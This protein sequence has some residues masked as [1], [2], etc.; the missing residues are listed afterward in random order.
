MHIGAATGGFLKKGPRTK[1]MM[2][3][4]WPPL[5][6][7]PARRSIPIARLRNTPLPP[8]C[9]NHSFV[10][11]ARGGQKTYQSS[12]SVVRRSR[13]SSGYRGDLAITALWL[14]LAQNDLT[15][16]RMLDVVSTTPSWAKSSRIPCSIGTFFF[17][18]FRSLGSRH[19][20]IIPSWVEAVGSRWPK[21]TLTDLFRKRVQENYQ[22]VRKLTVSKYCPDRTIQVDC[23]TA[24]KYRRWAAWA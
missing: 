16:I 10:M 22:R 21:R 12:V 6:L 15:L 13:P 2:S 1:S 9:P 24:A 20:K 8:L 11:N 4:T 23:S 18:V 17:R 14:G 19:T 7:L 3:S 5:P